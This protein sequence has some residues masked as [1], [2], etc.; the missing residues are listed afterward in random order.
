MLLYYFVTIIILL[1]IYTAAYYII[2][3]NIY[4]EGVDREL[5]IK[6]SFIKRLKIN[7][8]FIAVGIAS[9]IFL[10]TYD[11][12]FDE[13]ITLKDS[14][15]TKLIGAGL[16]DII[17]KLWGYRIL[18]IIMVISVILILKYIGKCRMKKLLTS[19][20]IVPGYLV[21]MFIIL[22]LFNAIY[23]NNNRLDKEKEY[24]GYNLDYTK[25]AYNLNFD[26][27]EYSNSENITKQDLEE[28]K[29]I[30]QNI[31]LVDE[32]T[33]LKNLN[34]LQ[35]NLGYY[36][37]RTTK[38]L[39]YAVD[40]Q[41]TL[42]YVSPR[43]ISTTD[44]STYNNKTYEYTHGFGSIVTYANRVDDAGNIEYIQKDFASSD[45]KIRVEEPRIY[46][47]LE[48]NNA[49]ITNLTNK[50]EFDYPIS[51]IKLAENQYEG[52]AGIKLSFI[53]RLILSIANKD[54]DITFSKVSER[55]KV[56]LNRNIIQRAKKILPEL[57]YDKQPYL[58][59]TDDGK[60]LWV[61]DAYTVSNEYPYSQRTTIEAEGYNRQI[62][63][64]RNSIKVLV[65]SY[66]GTIDFYIMDKTDPIAVAYTKIYPN[67]FK[68]GENIPQNISSHFVY[69]EYLYNVQA[70]V[71]KLYH[72][73]SEDVIY[74]GDDIWDFA[75]YSANSKTT[76]NTKLEPYYTLLKENGENKIG[77]VIPYTID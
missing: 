55:S 62:N 16:N 18:S 3:F 34:S 67:I 73:V 10:N 11:I 17:I 76:V 8:F 43:E 15:S 19:I 46:F 72:N 27:V 36:T 33:T 4:L 69:P 6:S 1:T 14:L 38:L 23:V 75:T 70:E 54:I 57:K 49:I 22:I 66:N 12:V 37:Y 13:F 25:L 53:D 45:N 44:T 30:I 40:G 60:Q 68:N 35:T 9:I 26:E 47:G 7:A 32:E 56:L 59:I 77:I 20:C 71:L 31:Q 52:K 2:V 51:A 29:D 74:R 58:I 64:I 28:N 42:V 39:K 41:D 21:V 63:Y 5:L 65:D 24:I 48:T 50:L 61:L